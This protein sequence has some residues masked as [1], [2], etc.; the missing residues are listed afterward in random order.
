MHGDR[1]RVDDRAASDGRTPGRGAAAHDLAAL[2]GRR[3]RA[4]RGLPVRRLPRRR[5]LH[6]LAGAAAGADP[7]GGP[8]AVQR[9][10][11]DGRQPRR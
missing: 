10:L 2:A 8:V 3:P 6:G 7:R 1:G 11:C 9:A 4:P 5:R